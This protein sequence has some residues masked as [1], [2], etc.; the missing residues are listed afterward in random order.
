M[1]KKWY[2]EDQR[3][4]QKGSPGL[5]APL[6]LSPSSSTLRV[7]G[8]RQ[9]DGDQPK[10]TARGTQKIR[11]VQCAPGPVMSR[12]RSKDLTLN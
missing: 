9:P 6:W 1:A 2:K 12:D 7:T 3:V 10:E 11:T 5:L 4:R 8:M